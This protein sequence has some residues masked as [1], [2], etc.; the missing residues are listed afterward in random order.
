MKSA[1]HDIEYHNCHN[2]LNTFKN[3]L[4]NCASNWHGA[5]YS[6]FYAPYIVFFQS[7]GTGK[8]K[9]LQQLSNNHYVLYL[10]LRVSPSSGIPQATKYACKF[11]LQKSEN[12]MV[13]TVAFLCACIELLDNKSIQEWN[14]MQK[15]DKFG[16]VVEE[17]AGEYAEKLNKLSKDLKFQD[18][19]SPIDVFW[20][21]R[22]RI[23]NL[24][25]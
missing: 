5:Y 14:D 9:L 20:A 23:R 10:C 7:S 8:S 3:H 18:F 11:L 6:E 13:R 19:Q 16:E 25:H 21:G 1:F 4:N 22:E 2:V 15:T 17:K 24:L 12:I